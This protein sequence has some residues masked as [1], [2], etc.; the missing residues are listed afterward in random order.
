MSTMPAYH[1]GILVRDIA[2]ARRRFS[3]ALGVTFGP[4]EPRVLTFT[5]GEAD[6]VV[7]CYSVEGPPYIELIEA[8]GAGLFGVQHPE[9]VHHIG[10]WVTDGARHCAALQAKGVAADRQLRS[11]DGPYG[12][13][14]NFVWFNAPADLHG[15]RFE[16]VD[17]TVRAALENRFRSST[18]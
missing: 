8:T 18:R 4:V 2:E 10:A 7:L 17:D 5:S 12:H 3:A 16:F 6:E 14:E 15:V 1:V 11:V 13:S 9:G